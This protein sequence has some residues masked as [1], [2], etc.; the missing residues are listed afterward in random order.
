MKIVADLTQAADAQS[1]P[2]KG[3]MLPT[4]NQCKEAIRGIT[5]RDGIEGTFCSRRCRNKAL[6]PW[7]PRGKYNGDRIVGLSFK[8]SIRVDH[9]QWKPRWTKYTNCFTWLCVFVWI[10][11]VYGD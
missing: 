2:G 6:H 9:W 5:Y 1:S 3:K 11:A 4:C 8:A 7:W 10:E